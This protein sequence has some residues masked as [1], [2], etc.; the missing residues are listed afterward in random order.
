MRWLQLQ[1][2]QIKQTVVEIFAFGYKINT[3]IHFINFTNCDLC[4]RTILSLPPTRCTF[5][6]IRVCVIV[7]STWSLKDDRENYFFLPLHYRFRIFISFF[8]LEFLKNERSWLSCI[9]LTTLLPKKDLLL[10]IVCVLTTAVFSSQVFGRT[11]LG[12]PQEIVE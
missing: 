3:E 9:I 4:R 7:N 2:C 6:N 10:T 11:S 5:H 1:L 8:F 12:A